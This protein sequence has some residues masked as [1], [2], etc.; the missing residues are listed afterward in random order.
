MSAGRP[1]ELPTSALADA[2]WAAREQR[3]P[4]ADLHPWRKLDLEAAAAISDD[5]YRRAGVAAAATWSRPGSSAR[6]TSR[7][8]QRLGLVEPLVAPVLP[9]GLHTGVDELTLSLAELVAPKLEAEV[10]ILVDDFGPRLVPCIEVTKLRFPEWSVPPACAIADFGLQ[11][12]MV[13]GTAVH[14]R[15]RLHVDVRHDGAVVGE[16]TGES[17]REFGQHSYRGCRELNRLF[18][19]Q[20]FPG[21]KV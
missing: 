8:Q 21:R 2:L 18:E 9:A 14:A 15:A 5:L 6:S 12:C 4:L 7:P 11:G 1:A 10:G 16:G 3:V 13:F 19:G 17:T 20:S